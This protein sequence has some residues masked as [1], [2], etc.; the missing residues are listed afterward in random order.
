MLKCHP[1]DINPIF[2]LTF[3]KYNDYLIYRCVNWIL[4]KTPDDRPI[5]I[6]KKKKKRVINQKVII[7]PRIFISQLLLANFFCRRHFQFLRPTGRFQLNFRKF[8]NSQFSMRFQINRIY[9]HLC[10]KA[11]AL[12]YG[13]WCVGPSRFTNCAQSCRFYSPWSLGNTHRP[14]FLVRF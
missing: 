4:V 1:E 12:C 2:P 14:F 3:S 8:N 9:Q 6:L 13:W 5:R 10:N 11:W 7:F